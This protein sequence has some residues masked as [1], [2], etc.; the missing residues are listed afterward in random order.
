MSSVVRRPSS[1]I[2]RHRPSSSFVPV[3]SS[4]VVGRPSSSAKTHTVLPSSATS[5][6]ILC[7]QFELIDSPCR[8]LVKGSR[9]IARTCEAC[10]NI[11]SLCVKAPMIVVHTCSIF[12]LL[13]IGSL[14]RLLVDTHDSS[15]RYARHARTY[16]HWALTRRLFSY[17]RVPYYMSLGAIPR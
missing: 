1:C 12:L 15:R 4:S 5:N 17:K 16:V 14:C 6:T 11:L 13:L 3:V 7:T 2:R 10:A 9:F 8:L